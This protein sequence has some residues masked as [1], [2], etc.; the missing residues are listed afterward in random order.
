MI[1]L[2]YCWTKKFLTKIKAILSSLLL[3]ISIQFSYSQKII[4]IDKIEGCQ[5]LYPNMTIEE[6]QTKAVVQAKLNALQESGISE[7]I[8]LSQIYEVE[9]GV[10][11]QQDKFYESTSTD[12]KGEIIKFN[13]LNYSQSVGSTGEILIC[14]EAKIDI[15][16]HDASQRNNN[17]ALSGINDRYKRGDAI[18]FKL[19]A[20]FD[21][22]YWVFWIDSEGKYQL[23]YPISKDQSN[24]IKENQEVTLPNSNDYIW[25]VD[26]NKI[27]EINSI[28]IVYSKN[29]YLV[30][31]TIIDFNSWSNWYQKL[32]Y[33][34]RNK[35]IMPFKIYKQ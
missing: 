9:R 3:L 23:I 12:V 6:A 13:L 30:D 8:S 33:N 32:E 15:L 14:A 4:E 1:N 31:N 16:K 28:L 5:V 20:A 18:A 2:D 21:L 17:I 19:K 10:R 22:Y 7:Q 27:E 24:K 35:I 11:V 34:S 29:D 25:N 26:T